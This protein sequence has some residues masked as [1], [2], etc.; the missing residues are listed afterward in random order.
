MAVPGFDELADLALRKS[1]HAFRSSQIY[2]L[3]ARLGEIMRR[4]NFTELSELADCLK[5]RPNPSF[6]N[7]VVAAML[8]KDTRF[9]R[10]RGVLKSIVRDVLPATAK[11]R[12]EQGIDGPLRIWCAGGGTGQEAYSLAILLDEADDADFFGR[13]VE[14]FS[15]D[16]CKRSIQ[17]A[18]DGR[19]DN[20]EIQLGLSA[21]RMLKYFSKKDADWLANDSLR[22]SI[23]FEVHNLVEPFDAYEPFDVVICRNVLSGILTPIARDIV[24][25]ICATLREDGLLFL[26]QDETLPQDLGLYRNE[27]FP[28]SWFYDPLKRDKAAVA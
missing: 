27:E 11:A 24:G 15:S 10:D 21:A 20:F 2:L 17:R 23:S 28:A 26:G 9:F 7:E 12:D 8:G 14:I 25:N 18:K 5:A 16:F 13:D 4:E 3:E 6:E 1:G 22:D 19:Y